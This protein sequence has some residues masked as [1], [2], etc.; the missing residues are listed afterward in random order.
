MNPDMGSWFKPLALLG[1]PCRGVIMDNVDVIMDVIMHVIMDVN[2]IID[3][4]VNMQ[5]IRYH[6]NVATKHAH[7]DL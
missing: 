7:A 3:N 2:V 6:R 5:E 1:G 4:V